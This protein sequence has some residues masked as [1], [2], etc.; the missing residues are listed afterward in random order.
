[1][2]DRQQPQA[3]RK[4]RLADEIPWPL[5]DPCLERCDRQEYED[6]RDFAGSLGVEIP[7]FD[8]LDRGGVVG[9]AHLYDCVDQAE[10]PW[11]FGKYRF[12]VDSAEP[13]PF[14]PYK[15]QLGFFEVPTEALQ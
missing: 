7:G 2:A 3:H 14:M 8:Q 6:T 4:L 12:V 10:S 13:V 9:V 1:V 11:F 5:P 15:G